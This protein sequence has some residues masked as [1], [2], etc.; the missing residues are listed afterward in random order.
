MDIPATDHECLAQALKLLDDVDAMPGGCTSAKTWRLMCALELAGCVLN[1]YRSPATSS[2]CSR[3]SLLFARAR[4]ALYEP[5][6][7]Q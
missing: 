4:R 5:D 2:A 1:G 6:T 7:P 3:A